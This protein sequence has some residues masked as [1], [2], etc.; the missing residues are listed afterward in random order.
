MRRSLYPFDYCTHSSIEVWKRDKVDH[1]LCRT[2]YVRLIYIRWDKPPYE[3]P[4]PDIPVDGS[5]QHLGDK[6][7]LARRSVQQTTDE[8]L[9]TDCGC[10]I[11][12]PDGPGSWE[13]VV[14]NGFLI[15]EEDEPFT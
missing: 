2:C 6:R 4:V 11:R 14:F 10:A 8:A 12:H 13:E 7:P 5:C 1:A 3:N 9:C 15:E